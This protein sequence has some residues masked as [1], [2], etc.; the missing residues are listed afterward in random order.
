MILESSKTLLRR[1][2]QFGSLKNYILELAIVLP[3]RGRVQ[4]DSVFG[5]TTKVALGK[6][7]KPQE[8]VRGSDAF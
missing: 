7:L 1:K 4:L 3:N 2:N 8:V 6:K 5:F